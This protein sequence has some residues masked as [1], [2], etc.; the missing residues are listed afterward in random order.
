MP[1]EVVP[2]A[3]TL[4]RPLD[5]TGHIGDRES[6]ITSHDNTQMRHKRRE[7]IVSHLRTSATDRCDQRTLARARKSHQTHVG[8]N[9]QL[10]PDSPLLSVLTEKCETRSLPGR[11][12]QCGISEATA[13]ALGDYQLSP[14]AHQTAINSPESASQHQRSVRHRQLDVCTV[15]ASPVVALTRLTLGCRTPRLPMEIHKCG[16]TGIDP[17]H[18]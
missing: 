9:L 5:Q 16:E 2:Q 3:P 4:G 14:I 11:R 15:S 13:P 12:R 8:E 18:D 7:R 6:H 1:Q 10:Q 17:E